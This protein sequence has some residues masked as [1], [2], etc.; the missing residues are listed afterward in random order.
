M[1]VPTAAE[2][3]LPTLIDVHVR[4][5]NRDSIQKINKAEAE[6]IVDE[7]ASLVADDGFGE[8]SIGVVS[9]LGPDQGKL[10]FD[11]LLERIGEEAFLKHHIRCGDARTFQGSEADVIFI[12]AV[13]DYQSGAVM[14]SNKLDNIRRINVAASRAKDRLYFFHSFARNDLSELDLRARLMDHFKAP[15]QGLSNAKG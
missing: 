6:A 1:R 14:T 13:D 8:R 4:S 15:I 11:S 2:R 10:I 12:S 9:L 7:I 5:G 3:L